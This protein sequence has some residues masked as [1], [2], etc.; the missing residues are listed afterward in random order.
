MEK[1][2]RPSQKQSRNHIG[3]KIYL[4]ETRSENSKDDNQTFA[5]SNILRLAP[6]ARE[7]LP[8]DMDTF[9]VVAYGGK[10]SKEQLSTS[11]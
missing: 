6:E 8:Q 9:E 5:S 3:Q 4:D 11:Y 2:S 10:S 7:T 1:S